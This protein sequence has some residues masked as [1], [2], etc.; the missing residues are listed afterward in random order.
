MIARQWRG[1]TRMAD[2]AAYLE[3][4]EATGLKEYRA[5]PGNRGTLV[6]TREVRGLAEFLLLSYWDSME[7]VGGFAG[8]EPGKAVF[9]PEDDRFLVERDLEV[10]H[11]EVA[12]DQR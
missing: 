4:L 11:F 8:P 7:S 1:A 10:Q 6:L 9:Y 5:T 3:Y 2:R 12:V